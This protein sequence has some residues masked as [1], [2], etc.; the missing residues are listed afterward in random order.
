MPPF[1]NPLLSR[2]RADEL[3]LSLK[4]N[5]ESC[6]AIELAAMCGF[7]CLWLDMEHTA[8]DWALLENMIR[9]AKARGAATMVRVARGSYSDHIKP[10]E[11]DADAV[12]VPHVTGVEDA[13][14]LVQ[15][16]RFH[17]VGMRPMDGGNTDGAF[18]LR[19]LAQYLHESN[20]ERLIGFQIEDPVALEQVEEMAALPGYDMLFFGPGDF[21]QAIGHPGE[22]SHPLVTEARRKVAEAC[23]RHGKIAATV[24]STTTLA[25][26]MALGYRFINIG[27]D[28]HALSLYCQRL[29]EEAG[30]AAKPA[31]QEEERLL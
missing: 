7:P 5:L 12:L 19:P 9:A 1:V 31:V 27:A 13:R 6:R 17:P 10:L 21:S 15:Q 11:L 20:H 29:L 28:V 22:M 18:T 16:M 24:G 8:T 25:D 30:L 2:L 26:Y 14:Q 3:V 4:M 23:R